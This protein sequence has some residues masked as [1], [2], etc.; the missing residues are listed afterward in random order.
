LL[1]GGVSKQQALDIEFMLDA[2][3]LSNTLPQ[4]GGTLDLVGNV[5]G[6]FDQPEL[7]Y[8]LL[9]NDLLVS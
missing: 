8:E 6:S 2:P 1:N 4:L 5:T 7:S 9:G 3:D